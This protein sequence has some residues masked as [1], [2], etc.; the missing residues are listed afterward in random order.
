MI[1]K[2]AVQIS[3]RIPK[4]FISLKSCM[5]TF[6]FIA[7]FGLYPFLILQAKQ[8]GLS[9]GDISIVLGIIPVAAGICNPPIGKT[10]KHIIGL[11]FKS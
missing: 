2:I 11:V 7:L 10:T 5:I 8:I 9:Y 4:E 6:T 1:V 3:K